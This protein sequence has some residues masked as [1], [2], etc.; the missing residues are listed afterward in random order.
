MSDTAA[1]VIVRVDDDRYR[2]DRTTP[3][4]AGPAAFA[5][6]VRDRQRAP[7]GWRLRPLVTMQG[8]KSRIWPTAAEVFASTK[9]V[10]P[11]QARRMTSEEPTEQTP[12]RRTR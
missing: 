7:L 2:L 5:E 8:S 4:G 9:L 1:Y 10:T 11:G 6:R 12:T 3:P